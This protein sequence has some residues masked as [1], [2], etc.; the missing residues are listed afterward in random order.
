MHSSLI[1]AIQVRLPSAEY[2]KLLELKKIGKIIN[3]TDFANK[4]VQEALNKKYAEYKKNDR[5]S[6]RE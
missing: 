4:V 1:K 5:N 3:P 6:E 2:N